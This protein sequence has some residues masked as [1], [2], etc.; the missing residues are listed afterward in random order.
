MCVKSLIRRLNAIGQAVTQ[1]YLSISLEL[2]F[3]RVL[4]VLIFVAAYALFAMLMSRGLRI[5]WTADDWEL[6][7]RGVTFAGFE[8]DDEGLDIPD[9]ALI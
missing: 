5:F 1:L 7:F 9:S 8:F 3:Q 4:L 2:L 6:N